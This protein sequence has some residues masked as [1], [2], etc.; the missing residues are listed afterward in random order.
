MKKRTKYILFGVLLIVALLS[1]SAIYI[2]TIVKTGFNINETVYIYIDEKKD[3]NDILTQL[4]TTAHIENLQNFEMISQY[5]DYPD[6]IKTGRY[7]I[8]PEMTVLQVVRLLNKGQQ[9]P[10]NL[11]FNNIRTKTDLAE[12]ISK[13]LMLNQNDLLS[14]LNDPNVCKAL[15]FDTE[16][17]V[18][19]FI[20]NTYNI[21]WDIS[22][23]SFLDRMNSEYK[24]FW[25]EKR[26]G[27]A[28]KLGLTP[29]EVSTLASI[30]E[31]ECFYSDEYPVVAGLYLNRINK[32]MLLQADP[33]IKFAIN[34]FSLKRVLNR[35]KDAAKSSPYSTYEHAGL[36]PGPIRVPSIKGI[37]G[38][39]NPAKHNYLFMCAKE[40]FSGR[41]NFAVTNAEHERNAARYHNAL[42][43]RKIF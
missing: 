36:P 28:Q 4:D 38:T 9:T 14:A 34:D 25:T 41:H 40:D 3:Y 19:M 17:I 6:N 32:N 5:M 21:Y 33:T 43:R 8:K 23:N 22:L 7:A 20:P 15:G 13:Q 31:E 37:D 12:R 11:K 16:T 42:N 2:Y 26:K 39:L 18:A 35:H 24:K 30:V 10:V 27:E 1:A 29:I